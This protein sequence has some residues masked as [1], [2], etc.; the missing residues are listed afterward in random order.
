M[1]ASRNPIDQ[2]DRPLGTFARRELLNAPSRPTCPAP[3]HIPACAT[4]QAPSKETET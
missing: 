1:H 3:L 4:R 2:P